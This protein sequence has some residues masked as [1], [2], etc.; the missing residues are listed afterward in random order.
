MAFQPRYM[1]QAASP[2][3]SDGRAMRPAVAGTVRG[4]VDL[5]T[6]DHYYRG[7]VDGKPATTFPHAV[8]A[9]MVQRGQ[10]RFMIYCAACHGLA[11]EGD[12][13]VAEGAKERLDPQWVKP[14]NLHDP[15]AR[16]LPVGQIFQTITNGLTTKGINTMPSYAAQIPVADRWAIA[17]YV[18]ALQRT[19]TATLDD[20]AEDMRHK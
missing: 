13:M 16:Q 19:T 12:G 1:T 15:A 20:V 6:D 5:A 9:A 17:L 8:S 2:L 10:Q 18:R 4:D 14:R 3:F 11:G 7:Q